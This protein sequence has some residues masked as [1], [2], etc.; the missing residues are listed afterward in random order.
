[1]TVGEFLEQFKGISPDLRLAFTAFN[2]E[3]TVQISPECVAGVFFPES[4]V[5]DMKITNY[6]ENK[7]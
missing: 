3:I 2:K 4:V 6:Y 7:M 5:I 1:V